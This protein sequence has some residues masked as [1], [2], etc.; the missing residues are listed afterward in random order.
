MDIVDRLFVAMFDNLNQNCRK[1]LEAVGF[2]YP[3]EPLKVRICII[4][5]SG[6]VICY[7][8]SCILF[9]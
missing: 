8:L 4:L 3:F 6:F 9:S 2:Q 7:P 1:D 5:V